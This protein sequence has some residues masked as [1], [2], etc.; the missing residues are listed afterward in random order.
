MAYGTVGKFR[1]KPGHVDDA[2]GLV[3]EWESSRKPNVTGAIAGYTYQLD[4]DPNTLMVAAVF[5]DKAAYVANADDPEQDK[6]FSR[7][8]EHFA[9][10]PEWND[11]EIVSG[12]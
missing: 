10:E 7:M 2:I 12:A 5:A 8:A 3:K 1:I 6:W 9:G 4:S 11:G